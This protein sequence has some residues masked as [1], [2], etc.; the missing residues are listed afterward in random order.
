MYT[1][2]DDISKTII[3]DYCSSSH[4]VTSSAFEIQ[5]EEL[6][7]KGWVPYTARD[8]RSANPHHYIVCYDTIIRSNSNTLC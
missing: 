7:M 2:G 6:T 8:V 5:L 1:E 4:D 3:E